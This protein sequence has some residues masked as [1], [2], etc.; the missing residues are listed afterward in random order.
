MPGL[1]SPVVKLQHR[2]RSPASH[3]EQTGDMPRGAHDNHGFSTTRCPTSKPDA[4]GPSD[5]TSATTSSPIPWGNEQKPNIALSAPPSPKSSRICFE[6][7]P[8]MPV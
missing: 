7:E 2:L 3:A 5:A 6:S 8:Q 1:M 4:D